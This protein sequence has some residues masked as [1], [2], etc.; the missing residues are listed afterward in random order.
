MS[1]VKTYTIN[2]DNTVS[3][4]SDYLMLVKFRLTLVVVFSSLLGYLIAAGPSF[5][6][7][8]MVLLM[9]GGFLVTSAANALNQVLEREYDILMTRTADRPVTAGR[10]KTSEAVLFAGLSCLAGVSL[11]SLFNGMTAFLGMLSLVIYAFVY[12]PMKRYSSMAV[13]VGAIPGALPVL[14]GTTAVESTVTYLGVL[15]FSVQFFWQFPHFWSIGYNSFEDYQSA[16]YKLIP[17]NEGSPDRRIG[18]FSIMYAIAI[19]PV[20]GLLYYFGYTGMLTSAVLLLWSITY[21]IFSAG[22]DR[23]F[24]KTSALRLM[25]FSFLYLPVFL[26]IVWIFK[27]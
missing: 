2:T 25:F 16:G 13:V 10:M 14:I 12:T 1:K 11:L 5:S 15:L 9:V 7:L 6:W 18:K 8:N 3:K 26:L 24:D 27:F 22:F 21:V 20:V 4:L 17:T 19:L 23:R